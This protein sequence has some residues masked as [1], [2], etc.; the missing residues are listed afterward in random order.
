M[1]P[2]DI[3][4]LLGIGSMGVATKSATE[5]SLKDLVVDPCTG[6]VEKLDMVTTGLRKECER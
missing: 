2:K 1:L 6:L 3:Q 4:L 5:T